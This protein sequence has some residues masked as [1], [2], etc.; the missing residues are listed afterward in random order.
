[1]NIYEMIKKAKESAPLSPQEAS[2]EDVISPSFVKEKSVSWNDP[3]FFAGGSKKIP[4]WNLKDML[5]FCEERYTLKNG[6]KP[7]F[8]IRPAMMAMSG[9][10]HIFEMNVSKHEVNAFMHSYIE[11]YMSNMGKWWKGSSKTWYP[12]KMV[13]DSK[14]KEF[15]RNKNAKSSHTSHAFAKRPVN[16]IL[17]EEFY[18]G[19]AV[20]FIAAYGII[21]PAA[22]VLK[23]KNF[24]RDDAM[25]FV[26]DAIKRGISSGSFSLSKILEIN[27]QYRP[28]ERFEEIDP[29]EFLI[30]VRKLLS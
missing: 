14:V 26:V 16:S 7:D 19:D 29:E 3:S 24:S 27:E 8:A 21:I 10:R 4:E 9:L 18:R 6:K 12:Q 23:S 2:I 1:M 11:W 28:F 13:C 22:F 25:S 5:K 15:L 20:E 30:S 17:L